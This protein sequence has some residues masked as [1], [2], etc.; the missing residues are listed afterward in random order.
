VEQICFEK[1]KF[2]YLPSTC[3]LDDLIEILILNQ[4]DA[5][6]AMLELMTIIH[7]LNEKT[8]KI[9]DIDF[10]IMRD[11]F[12]KCFG[13]ECVII[14]HNILRLLEFEFQDFNC[15]KI[16]KVF[17]LISTESFKMATK[18]DLFV[19]YASLFKRYVKLDRDDIILMEEL[20]RAQ[21][22]LNLLKLISQKSIENNGDEKEAAK[23]VEFDED[24][25]KVPSRIKNV[26]EMENVGKQI[27]GFANEIV[28]LNSKCVDSK[29]RRFFNKNA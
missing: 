11:L 21:D 17:S 6:Y 27:L 7:Q 25:A 23:M 13:D 14:M 2:N 5:A 26:N 20:P 24:F 3:V 4:V 10:P 29:F 1:S 19:K 28:K 12:K 8:T 9:E 22:N 18:S 15:F 16:S